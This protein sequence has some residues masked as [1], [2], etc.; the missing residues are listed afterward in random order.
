MRLYT[1][2]NKIY[3]KRVIIFRDTVNP[4]ATFPTLMSMTMRYGVMSLNVPKA[5][6]FYAKNG[7][8]S[9]KTEIADQLK[10][11]SFK[12]G[13][14][15]DYFPSNFSPSIVLKVIKEHFAKLPYSSKY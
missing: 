2:L 13:E 5:V 3:E 6:Q 8:E 14:D 9:L 12:K 11:R 7:S 10:M 4:E 1:D 15:P